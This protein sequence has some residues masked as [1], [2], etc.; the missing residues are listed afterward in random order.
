MRA[1]A[2]KSRLS[3]MMNVKL[4]HV[5]VLSVSFCA[6]V[7]FVDKHFS[8]L[9]GT[10]SSQ[11]SENPSSSNSQES[12]LHDEMRDSKH[13]NASKNSDNAIPKLATL[14]I[15]DTPIDKDDTQVRTLNKVAESVSNSETNSKSSSTIHIAMVLKDAMKSPNLQRK[16]GITVASIFQHS[17]VSLEWHVFGD[18]NSLNFAQKTLAQSFSSLPFDRRQ[19]FSSQFHLYK[20]DDI[21]EKI[22][23]PVTILMKYFT[24]R[25][26]YYKD[27]IFFLSTVLHTIL[28]SAISRV[29]M[30]DADLK[31]MT[32]I[33]QLHDLFNDFSPS[34]AIGIGYEMQPVY[35]HL[36]WNYR[37]NNKGTKVGEAS[38]NGGNP[39]FNSGVLL[40][41]LEKLRSSHLFDFLNLESTIKSYVTK[42]SFDNAHLGDQDFYTLTS[43]EHPEFYHILPCSWNR[44]LCRW[45]E[46]KG[47]QDVF[48]DYFDCHQKINLYH[49]NCDTPIPA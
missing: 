6:L 39:G 45:W 44:Q 41:D 24:G 47:Y 8:S 42:Y 11:N 36:F 34:S 31:F 32:N 22:S 1:D 21:E 9:S 27:S 7:Y 17:S 43:F 25:H 13:T 46:D 10:L 35:R 37:N 33:K 40:L 19:Q 28:D 23:G 4:K 16:F 12:S 14:P 38:V 18:D 5:L 29:I 49:G 15:V 48:G 3:A 26:T 30:I 20:L 2:I